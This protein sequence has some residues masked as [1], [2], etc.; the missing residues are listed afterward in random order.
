MILL[1]YGIGVV[2]S[3]IIWIILGYFFPK[4]KEELIEGE[5]DDKGVSFCFHVIF[6]PFALFGLIL[7]VVVAIIITPFV[8]LYDLECYM[9]KKGKDRQCN[10]RRK[11]QFQEKIRNKN[12]WE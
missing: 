3:Y 8:G 11:A 9:D 10:K 5:G 4:A 2:I 7:L 12:K 6:W 1:I